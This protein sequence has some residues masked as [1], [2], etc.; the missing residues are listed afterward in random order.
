MTLRNPYVKIS[1]LQKVSRRISA[2]EEHLCIK[3]KLIITRTAGKVSL[4]AD[5]W[6]SRMYRGYMAVKDHWIL[7]ECTLEGV[8]LDFRRFHPSHIRDAACAVLY[9]ATEEWDLV[10]PFRASTADNGSDICSS[11]AKLLN[12]FNEASFLLA[13]RPLC[14]FHVRCVAHIVN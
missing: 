3:I 1:I 7:K 6:S 5:A 9:E 14:E 12:Y 10:K 8:L 2:V 13:L 11:I 4:T